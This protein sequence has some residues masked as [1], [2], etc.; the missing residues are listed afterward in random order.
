MLK[1]LDR[2]RFDEVLD[3]VTFARGK[4]IDCCAGDSVGWFSKSGI[5]RLSM[6]SQ[7]SIESRP[8]VALVEPSA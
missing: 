4:K 7:S 3:Y 1:V 6:P 8:S 2:L 5:L